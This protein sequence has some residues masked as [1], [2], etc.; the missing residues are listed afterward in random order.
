[1]TSDL[2]SA[3]PH[4]ISSLL[5]AKLLP[6]TLS[7]SKSSNA[8]TRTKAIR[9]FNVIASKCGDMAVRLKVLTEVL[10]L[11]KTG[12][13]ASAEHRVCLFTMSASIPPSDDISTYVIET[14]A[15]LVG[16][17]TNEA[18]LQALCNNIHIHLAHI[19]RSDIAMSAAT[20]SALSKDLN[21]SKVSTRREL[22]GGIGGAIWDIHERS[23]QLSKEGEKFIG[24]LAS[25]FE[26]NLQTASSNPASN[27]TGFLEGYVPAALALGPLANVS[28]MSKLANCS[29]MQG[30][31]VISPKPSFLLNNKAYTKLPT[32]IDR[33]WLLRCLESAV[34]SQGEKFT[35]SSV[36]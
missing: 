3:A 23:Q 32:D 27:P 19:L 31:F 6:A 15:P 9:L 18:A 14:L 10:A 16:K 34:I 30:L 20:S 13:T 12:K 29:A 2:L 8:E 33:R 1:M 11:P 36:R 5:P 22:S 4:D 35:Q 28:S 26:T 17:E 21:S 7:A 25:S 24:V